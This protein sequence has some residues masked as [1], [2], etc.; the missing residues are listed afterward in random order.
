MPIPYNGKLFSF[1]NP[2]GSEITVRGWGNQFVASF[3]TLDGYTVTKDPQS[4]F[5]HYATLSEDRERLMPS[6]TPV[7]AADPRSIGL[8][9]HVRPSRATMRARAAAALDTPNAKRRWEERR[10]Q[11]RNKLKALADN[12]DITQSHFAGEPHF[13]GT[14]GNYLGLCLLVQF[15]DVPATLTQSQVDEFCNK[16]GYNGFGNNGSVYDYFLAVSDGKLHY[17]NVV[18]AYYTT[19]HPRSYYTDPNIVQGIRARELIVEALTSLKTSGFDFSALSSDSAGYIHALNVFYAG[20]CVNNWAEG[21]WPHSTS[22]A[23]PF[24]VTSTKKFFDY[25]ITET[26]TQLTLGT[27]CHENG[28]M[29]CDFPDLYDYDYD[30]KGVGHY[31]LMAYGGSDINPPQVDAYLKDIVGWTSKLTT[32]TE[33]MTVTLPAGKNEFLI[34]RNNANEYFIIENRQQTSRDASLPDAGL[35]IWHVDRLGSNNNNEMTSSKHYELSLEQF[36]NRFDLERNVNY[37]DSKDLYGGA[38]AS[39]FGV[40]TVPSSNWWDG[41]ASGLEIEQIS[42]PSPVMTIKIKGNVTDMASCCN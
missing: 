4:G 35:A 6:S 18:T 38:I 25:Q 26:G 16:I 39:K 9:K 31:S 1:H 7:G 21:L 19:Q 27:F 34:H 3:E 11:Q 14:T 28:H 32:L 37:G 2:D 12:E 22:L 42:K 41:T 10:E 5:Y 36:D 15:P 29:I 33:G 20:N 17:N 24:A 13:V 40:A 8:P 30:S 23:A